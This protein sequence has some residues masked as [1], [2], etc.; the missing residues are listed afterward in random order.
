MLFKKFVPCVENHVFVSVDCFSSVFL[1]FS[2][3]L[4][5]SSSYLINL[6]L[7]LR[8]MCSLIVKVLSPNAN[9]CFF[10]GGNEFHLS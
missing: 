9:I 2:F 4:F 6:S 7:V 8:I 1:Q 10:V 3:V 5:F